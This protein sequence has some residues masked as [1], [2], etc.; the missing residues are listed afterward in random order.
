MA[1]Y[2]GTL[3]WKIPWMGKPGR[4]QTMGSQRVGHDYDNDSQVRSPDLQHQRYMGTY[5]NANTWATT[6]N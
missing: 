3:P 1:T 6:Q 5:Y 2:S 4:L